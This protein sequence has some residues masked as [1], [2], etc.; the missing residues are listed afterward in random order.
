M[1]KFSLIT[2]LSLL[3][4][5]AGC[6]CCTKKVCKTDPCEQTCD[7]CDPCEAPSCKEDLCDDVYEVAHIAP[8]QQRVS[9]P[10]TDSSV[11]W[12]KEDYA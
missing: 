9:G 11:Q 5:L 12:D 7:P 10:L 4:L 8:Q 3:G 2:T 1:K 6:G